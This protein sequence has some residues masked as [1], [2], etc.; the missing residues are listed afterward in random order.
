MEHQTI[1]LIK[2]PLK[3]CAGHFTIFNATERERLHGHNY[4]LEASI[5]AKIVE[6]GI[7]FDYRIV[8][9]KLVGL[10]QQL[11]QRFLL[12]AQSPYLN[13][14]ERDGMVVA[15]FNGQDI[16]FP[17]DDVLLMPLTNIT[18]ETLSTWFVN[19]IVDDEA[20]IKTRYI[21]A[22]TIKVFNSPEQSAVFQWV[23]DPTICSDS[24]V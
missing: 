8:R 6:P 7:T 1:E 20:F 2:G 5:L 10:C 4:W 16:P 11:T 18:L 14:A 3:F 21:K 23:S 17:K 15:T 13:I 22:L 12:P 24:S 19:K 9:D